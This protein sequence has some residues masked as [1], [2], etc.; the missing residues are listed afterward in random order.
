MYKIEP[1]HSNL[2]KDNSEYF[3][4]LVNLILEKL[5]SNSNYAI[6]SDFWLENDDEIPTRNYLIVIDHKSDKSKFIQLGV[7]LPNYYRKEEDYAFGVA[8]EYTS[9]IHI[10]F[11]ENFIELYRDTLEF[12][13]GKDDFKQI[14][15]K[16]ELNIQQNINKMI[17]GR[18]ILPAIIEREL[19][20]VE[21][22]GFE[23][24]EKDL[25][26]ENIPGCGIDI[27]QITIFKDFP[28]LAFIK[29]YINTGFFRSTKVD[30]YYLL[31]SQMF[32]IES[33]KFIPNYSGNSEYYNAKYTVLMFYETAMNL[34]F[35]ELK[36]VY[37]DE[38]ISK[39]VFKYD[40]NDALKRSNYHNSKLESIIRR[41]KNYVL[42][43]Q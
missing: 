40:S 25:R 4:N 34:F 20:I 9:I 2:L 32:Y 36:C 18:V 21:K 30:N 35:I 3:E 16:I 12:I 1:K 33:R 6:R 31:S 43:I 26:S 11:I 41:F 39:E 29:N 42:S 37:N 22:I 7:T 13:F 5:F 15:S 8:N 28:I 38:I 23:G 14:L 10:V 27:D 19:S 24:Y 17:A